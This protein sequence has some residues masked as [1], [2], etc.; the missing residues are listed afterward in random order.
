MNITDMRKSLLIY[1]LVTLST[2]ATAQTSE[3]PFKGSFSNAEY[4]VYIRLNLYDNDVNVPSHELF[5][6]LPGF[7]GKERNSFCWLVTTAK[8]ESDKKATLSLIND[9]GSE[10]LTATLTIKDDST[11]VLRQEKGSALKV[12]NNGKWLKLPKTIEFKRQRR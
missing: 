3:K 5:G 2:L 10:D 11:A 6:P 8:V 4:H 1:L 9:Y 7:L 12:P